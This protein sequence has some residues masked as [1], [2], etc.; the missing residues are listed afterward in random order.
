[1]NIGDITF[2]RSAFGTEVTPVPCDDL[3][4]PEASTKAMFLEDV[5]M[6]RKFVTYETT[7]TGTPEPG[8]DQGCLYAAY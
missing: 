7:A 5:G 8:A 1:M 3:V 2:Y 6:V 4:A